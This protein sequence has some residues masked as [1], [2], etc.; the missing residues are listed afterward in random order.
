MITWYFYDIIRGS[1]PNNRNANVFLKTIREKFKESGKVETNLISSF[2]NVRYDNVGGV[3]D[4]VLK[5]IQA[6]TRLKELRV[7]LVD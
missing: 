5:N 7:P 1:I 6:S 2:M 4:F 3:R